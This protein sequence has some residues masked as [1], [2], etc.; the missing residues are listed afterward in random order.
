MGDKAKL[1]VLSGRPL[2]QGYAQGRAQEETGIIADFL[3]PTVNVSQHVAK[4]RKYDKENRFKIPETLRG[5]R[6]NAT[7]LDFDRGDK[8]YDCAPHA[9]DVA[10]DN[11]EIEEAEGENL[12]MEASDEAASLAGMAHEKETLDKAVSEASVNEDAGDFSNPDKDPVVLINKVMIDIRLAAGGGSRTEIGIIIDPYS[13][14]AFF[15]NKRV[16]GYFPKSESIAPT[17]ENMKSLFLGNTD[18]KVSWLA[19]DEAPAGK[20]AEIDFVLRGK[21]LIF[22]RNSTPTRRDPSFMKTF[23]LRNRWMRPGTYSRED[24]RGEVVKLDWS[25]DVQ[26]TN[27]EAGVLIPVK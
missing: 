27:S 4:F 24:G 17:L 1:S 23:R 10:L 8:N 13:V 5:L 9:L 7:R 18:A 26:V 22:A 21:M 16:K 25:K 15:A 6:G 14:L 11:I 3:A 12:L 20:A 2:I 19:T